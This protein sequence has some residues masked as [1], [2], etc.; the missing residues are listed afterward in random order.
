MGVEIERKFLV[1][2][3]DWRLFTSVVPLYVCQG[4]LAGDS[5]GLV[6]VRTVGS[7]EGWLTIKGAQDGITRPE[8]EYKIPVQD[9]IDLM[10]SPMR[11]GI[12][13]CKFRSF[14]TFGRH[15]WCI[16]EFCGSHTGLTIAEIELTSEA[17]EF[18]TP[19]WVGREVSYDFDYS[20]VVLAGA[21]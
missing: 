21:M 10:M 5:K 2:S 11:K 9:A 8:F 7:Q 3:R 14:V 17:E 13:L 20:N 4:Y 1:T 16:D 18:E 19:P 12:L 6:R 15:T